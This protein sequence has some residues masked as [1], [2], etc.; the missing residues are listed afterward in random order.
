MHLLSR[1][2]LFELLKVFLITLVGMTVDPAVGRHRSRGHSSGPGFAADF[3]ADPLCPPQCTGVRGPRHDSLRGLQ[4]LRSHV[5]RER[6]GGCQVDRHL[7]LD[8]PDPRVHSFFSDQSRRGLAQRHR[9]QLGPTG[10]SSCG[11]AIGRADC[12]WH[13]P[14]ARIVQ[15]PTV[16]DQRGGRAR[17]KADRTH[18]D[19]QHFGRWSPRHALCSRSRTAAQCGQDR[20][21]RCC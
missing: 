17:T 16:L 3:A 10:N 20:A 21:R 6:I 14:H 7:T 19:R 13:A 12:L 5:R 4:R 18:A 1:Y 15:L 11:A 2:I 9:L 8:F